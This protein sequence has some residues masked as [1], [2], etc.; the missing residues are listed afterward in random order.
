MAAATGGEPVDSLAT[1][2]TYIIHSHRDEV[3]P[4]APAERN[5][6]E[7]E[8]LGRKVK[9]EALD[10]PTHFDMGAYIPALRRAVAWVAQQ[11]AD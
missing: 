11:W 6:R 9:F 8:R 3:V 10:D 2:P 1:M 7:L 4:F 5:A